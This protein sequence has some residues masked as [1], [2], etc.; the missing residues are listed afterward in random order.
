LAT[1]QKTRKRRSREELKADIIAAGTEL[2]AHLGYNGPSIRDIAK[3]AEVA[4]PALYRFFVNKHDL[5][6]QCCR[7]GVQQNLDYLNRDLSLQEIKQA[8]PE[9]VLYLTTAQLLK[10]HY[11]RHK[12]HII[13]RALFDG[14]AELIRDQAEKVFGSEFFRLTTDA[15]RKVS[16]DRDAVIRLTMIHCLAFSFQP[17]YAF[18]QPFHHLE[19]IESVGAMAPQILK[20]V[21]PEVD[22]Q[23]VAKANQNH[24]WLNH[25]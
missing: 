13:S 19:P 11:D 18:W 10:Q 3:Q 16:N 17:I 7:E 14:D 2:F 25:K 23:K 22:W 4:L 20:I 1:T 5:Y 9:Q 6:V 15:S 8:T 24:T 21:Y 12:P